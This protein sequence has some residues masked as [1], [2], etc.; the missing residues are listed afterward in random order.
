M[1]SHHLDW[2]ATSLLQSNCGLFRPCSVPQGF[3]R[4]GADWQG[5]NPQQVKIHI[6]PLQSSPI[7]LWKGLTEQAL[8]YK[9][10]LHE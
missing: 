1:D 7:P 5:L 4:F 2:V 6:K 10:P 8:N 3:K 9:I